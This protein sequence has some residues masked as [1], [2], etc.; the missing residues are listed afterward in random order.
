MNLQDYDAGN[1]RFLEPA[2]KW[3]IS[4]CNGLAR[5]VT[6]FLEKYELGEAA[7]ALYDFIWG[8]F[9]DWY[10]ELIKPRLYGK[11][12]EES[13]RAAQNTLHAVLEKTMRLLHPFMPFITE[14]I[15]QHLVDG[16]TIMIEPWP[17]YDSS[18]EDLCGRSF[19]GC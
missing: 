16:E 2:D 10:I 11:F 12:T 5:E 7:R 3:I 4:R 17:A 6:R 18:L 15:W 8:E 9:C 19:Y 14:E 1:S 13:R